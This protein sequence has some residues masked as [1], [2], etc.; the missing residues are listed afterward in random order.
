M[1]AAVKVKKQGAQVVEL[2]LSSIA[3]AS[4]SLARVVWSLIGRVAHAKLSFC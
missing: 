4:R 2:L 3:E 1:A